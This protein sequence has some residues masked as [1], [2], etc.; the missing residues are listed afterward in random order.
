M[1]NVIIGI[2]GLSNKPEPQLLA[3]WWEKSIREGLKNRGVENPDFKF[4]MVNWAKLL[5]KFPQHDDPNFKHDPSYL[6][7]P[8]I[9]AVDGALV[10]YTETWSD[11]LR[12]W[13]TDR[14]GGLAERFGGSRLAALEDRVMASKGW[15]MPFYFDQSNKFN[16]G[17]GQPESARD[18]L[19]GTVIEAIRDNRDDR[20]MLISHSMGTI[21]TYDALRDL[22]RTSP[23]FE[24]AQFVTMGSPLGFTAV[25][26]RVLTERAYA[27]VRVRTPS[28]V[29][30][31]WVNYADRRDLIAAE[32][33]LRGDYRANA[34]GV[35][36]VDDL[37]H[38]D[39]TAL[40]G[41]RKPHKSFGYLRTPELS[42]QIKDFLG[43]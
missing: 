42:D 30:E 35:R 18:V 40:D 17:N 32:S 33:H 21:I 38:N 12:E 4:V 25:K 31:R 22:G 36:V 1:A 37:I 26:N 24:V 29:K 19:V 6:N 10:E 8:Y 43:A 34:T 14:I 11:R 27:D 39:Y 3:D 20:L 2:H 7:Q 9:E 23:G 16:D 15:E 13:V 5:Y 41:N 28:M